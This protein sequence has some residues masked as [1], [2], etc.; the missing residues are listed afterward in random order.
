MLPSLQLDLVV[1]ELRPEAILLSGLFHKVE[2]GLSPFF[3]GAKTAIDRKVTKVIIKRVVQVSGRKIGVVFHFE[4]GVDDREKDRD[5]ENSI[6]LPLC[7]LFASVVF[8][9]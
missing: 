6:A 2:M 1:V 7:E 9:N 3:C 8:Q 4:N 5:R